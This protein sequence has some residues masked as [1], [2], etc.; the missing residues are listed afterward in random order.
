MSRQ[1]LAEPLG[2][3]V[4]DFLMAHLS[5]HT[6]PVTTVADDEALIKKPA[7]VWVVL[8]CRWNRGS[9]PVM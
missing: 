6:T 7:L 5:F 9:G 4:V 3:S 2:M 8:P 1:L